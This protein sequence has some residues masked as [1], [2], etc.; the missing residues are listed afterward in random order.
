MIHAK[1]GVAFMLEQANVPVVPV[2]VIGTTDD[3][4]QRAIRGERPTLEM[5]IG[6]PLRLPPLVE[7][8]EARRAARQ[9]N[10]DWLMNHIAGLLPEEYRGVY[11]DTSI[12]QK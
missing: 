6:K 10:T 5:R 12:L 3:F 9:R 1:A 8:G 4:F 2:G 7:K 11:K